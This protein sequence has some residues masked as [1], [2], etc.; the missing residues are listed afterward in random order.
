[1]VSPSLLT[2]LG[3]S[4]VQPP[5]T[6]QKAANHLSMMSMSQL[7]LFPEPSQAASPVPTVDDVRARFEQM[8]G[9]LRAATS[10][11]PFTDRELAYWET[12]TP[13]MANWLPQDEREAVCIEFSDHISRLSRAA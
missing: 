13:Q 6:L 8:L 2:Y 4:L 3:M 9:R 11:L 7:S 12:V 5:S 10:D 1:M